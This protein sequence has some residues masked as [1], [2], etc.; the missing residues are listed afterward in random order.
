[1][2]DIGNVPYSAKPDGLSDN[3]AAIQR[4]LSDC[5]GTAEAPGYV[6]VPR[7]AASY[8][9]GSLRLRTE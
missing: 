2:C 3:T 6:I 7:G 1:M 4:V 8:R 9:A 5:A